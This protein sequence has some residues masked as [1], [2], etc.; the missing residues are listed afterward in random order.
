MALPKLY[1]QRETAEIL[2]YGHYRSLDRLITSGKLE[3]VKIGGHKLF[4]EHHINN[5]LKSV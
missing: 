2:R 4:S 3:C 1:N 5:Y